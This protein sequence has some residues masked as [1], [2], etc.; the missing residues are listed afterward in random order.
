[1]GEAT[2]SEV[3]AENPLA[4]R[5]IVLEVPLCQHLIDSDSVVAI[6]RHNSVDGRREPFLGEYRRLAPLLDFS[7]VERLR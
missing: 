7:P 4:T 6:T 2:G 1:M 3:G 5:S